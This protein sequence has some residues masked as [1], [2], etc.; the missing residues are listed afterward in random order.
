MSTLAPPRARDRWPV[1]RAWAVAA[2]TLLALVAAAA[3]RSTT[4]ALFEPLEGEFGWSRTQLSAAVTLNLVVYGLVAPFAAVLMERFPVR[5][6]AVGA[7][8][9]VAAGAGLAVLMTQVWH[10]LLLWG[11]LVGVGTGALAL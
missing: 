2:V 6:V 9:L 7:L 10:L 4:G 5:R 11:V 8:L 3:F 1:H